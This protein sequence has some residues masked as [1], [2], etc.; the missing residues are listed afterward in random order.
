MMRKYFVNY[1]MFFS[2][3]CFSG[4]RQEDP[5]LSLGHGVFGIEGSWFVLS[6]TSS[7]SDY[8][9][10]FSSTRTYDGDLIKRDKQIPVCIVTHLTRKLVE[11][12]ALLFIMKIFP[13]GDFLPENQGTVNWP[14]SIYFIK[15][16]ALCKWNPA[17]MRGH[18]YTSILVMFPLIL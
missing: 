2:V 10:F 14:E 4:V 6:E 16:L 3:I 18:F 12:F 9:M 5:C 13:L 11:G 1:K 8:R 15:M 7:L 17:M